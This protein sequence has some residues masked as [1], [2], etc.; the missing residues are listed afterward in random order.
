MK[1]S[2]ED[3]IRYADNTLNPERRQRLLDAADHDSELAETLAALDASN[4]PYKAAFDQQP[5]PPVPESLREELANLVSVANSDN[6]SHIGSRQKPATSL[7]GWTRHLAMAACLVLCVGIGFGIG[8][9]QRNTDNNTVAI[10][11]PTPANNAAGPSYTQRD[12]VERVADYQTLYVANTVSDADSDLPAALEKLESLG[13]A[14]GVKT[15]VPDLTAAGY[16]F[17]RAQELGFEGKTLVQVVYSKE[18]NSPLALC[19]M[20]ANGEQDELLQIGNRHGLGTASW[21]TDNQRFVIVGNESAD[22]LKN[23]YEMAAE[24]FTGA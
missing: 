5:Q 21:I 8:I 24:S 17:A 6:V 15:A 7:T 23:L 11:N 18:G 19:Y 14:S 3:L 10:S 13:K 22:T 4:L 9:S 1:F 16:Q 2:D 20:V 12:W